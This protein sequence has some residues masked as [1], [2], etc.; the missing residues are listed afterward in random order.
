MKLYYF[1]GKPA[2][3]KENPIVD[4]NLCQK[5]IRKVI[6]PLLKPKPIKLSDHPIA[7]FSY[8]FERAAETG[9]IGIYLLHSQSE[10]KLTDVFF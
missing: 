5:K 3:T 1:S 4:I 2:G 6:T 10:L 7:A 8:Y 9:L